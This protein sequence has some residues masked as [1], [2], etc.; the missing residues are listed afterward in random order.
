MD[1]AAR[2]RRA[3]A[4][5]LASVALWSTVATGFKLGLRDLAAVQLLLL[6]CVIALV[7]FAAAR[8]FV[9]A[10][11]SLRQHLAAGALGLVNPFAYYLILFEAYDRLPAQIAQPLNFTW[12]IALAL[13]AI[14]LLRQRL[15]AR[16]WIG[17]VV[18]YVGVVVI[19]TKG[20]FDGLGHFDPLG[21]ALALGSALIWAWYW[22]MTVRLGIHPVPLMLN[23]FAV[24]TCLV[25][26][27]CWATVGLPAL[28]LE[29]LG[30]GAWV[31]LI[32]TGV[33]F[34]LWQRAMALTK[35]SGKLGA[36]IF[37]APFLSLVLIAVV[38]GEAIHPSAVAG[39]ALIA[40]GLVLS[41]WSSGDNTRRGGMC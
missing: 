26:L 27:V 40:A 31:G 19:L 2:E 9:S 15:S 12:A 17:V 29:T 20:G 1:V 8:G 32:E 39:L 24:A 28:N 11:L 37:L 34:L 18:G 16:G 23:G 35:Q 21:V 4:Y 41:R 36:L 30:Y 22:I 7:F 3:L 33:A 10:K 38:L 5:A 25:T 14:P 6:G 13:L